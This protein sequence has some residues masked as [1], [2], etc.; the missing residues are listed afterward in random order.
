MDNPKNDN[1]YLHKIKTDLI[2][3]MNQMRNV[4]LS[5]LAQNEVLLD[6]M[7]FRMIQISENAKKLSQNFK[8]ERDN[9]P[10]H[11]LYGLRN[12]IV[13]DDGSVDIQIVYDTLVHNI[14]DI[15]SIIGE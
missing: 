13:H 14:P 9:V 10:W 7:M 4:D 8:A 6:S 15:L 11:S 12:R 5:E 1:Y 2:F 3:I